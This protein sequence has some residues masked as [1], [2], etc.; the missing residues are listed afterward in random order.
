LIVGFIEN[1]IL[2]VPEIHASEA[3]LAPD[4]VRAMREPARIVTLHTITAVVELLG[5]ADLVAELAFVR[6]VAIANT[7]A[8]RR[9]VAVE[10]IFVEG[11][12]NRNIAIFGL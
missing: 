10:R 8:V 2:L 1:V 3:I 11:R 5:K 7:F 12:T 4:A 6:I 9:A